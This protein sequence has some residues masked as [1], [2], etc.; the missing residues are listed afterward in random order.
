M[1]D[2]TIGHQ[3]EAV[4]QTPDPMVTRW[5]PMCVGTGRQRDN[6]GELVTCVT[7]AGRGLLEDRCEAAHVEDRRPCEGR[8]DAVRIID[9]E[10]NQA[11]GCVLH[12]AK[13][14]ASLDNARVIVGTVDGAA[15]ETYQRARDIKPFDFG[16]S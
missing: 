7:C 1:E 15:I 2:P 4:G 5:C 6:G 3:C 16:R 8:S 13:L 10:G 14:L 11:W 9:R 12:G